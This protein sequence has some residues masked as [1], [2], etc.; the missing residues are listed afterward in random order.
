MQL[1]N[2]FKESNAGAEGQK[3]HF[4]ETFIQQNLR[5]NAVSVLSHVHPAIEAIFV[6]QIGSQRSSE[7]GKKMQIEVDIAGKIFN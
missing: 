5:I 4:L 1:Q 7:V 3:C 6:S 2:V